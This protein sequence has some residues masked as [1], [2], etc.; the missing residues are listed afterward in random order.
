MIQFNATSKEMMLISL[1]VDRAM[2]I[3][4]LQGR[5]RMDLMM[6]LDATHSNGCP[7]DFQKLLDADDFNF[8]HDMSGISNCLDRDDDSPTAGQML[9]L[10]RPRCAAKQA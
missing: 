4:A 1:I 6:D 9:N 8:M 2:K 5:E 3:K 7:L 10:F